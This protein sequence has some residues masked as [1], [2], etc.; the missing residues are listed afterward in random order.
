MTKPVR[1]SALLLT[2]LA[3]T[4]LTGCED[5]PTR[6]Q[7]QSDEREYA[8]VLNSVGLTLT[9]FPTDAPDST[10]TIPLGANGTPASLATRGEVALVPLGIFPAVAVV[11]LAA[12]SVVDVIALPQG[13]GATGVAIVDDSLAFVANPELNTVS[14]VRYREGVA[15]EPIDVGVY[16]TSLV[17]LGNRVYVLEANLVDFSPDGPSSVSVIDA[18]ALDV[19]T[20]FMLSGRNAGDALLSGDSVLYVLNRGDFGLDNGSVSVV[21]LPATAERERFDGF[22][23]GTGTLSDLDGDLLVSSYVYGLALYDPETRSFLTAPEDGVFPP[24]AAN[25]LGAGADADDRL[26][27]I[28]AGDCTEPGRVWIWEGSL[29]D[30]EQAEAVTVGSCPLDILFTTF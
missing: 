19:D 27:S 20:T 28:D 16:P 26:Y 25:V 7:P 14:P 22:G 5:D 18:I 30:V 15:L 9:V 10:T 13:S 11:D 24:D 3:A 8:V 12:G 21:P 17:A 6:P 1:Y 29:A 4:A 2:A 23:A